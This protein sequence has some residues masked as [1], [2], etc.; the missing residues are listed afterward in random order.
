MTDNYYDAECFFSKDEGSHKDQLLKSSKE[1]YDNIAPGFITLWTQVL[2]YF[3]HRSPQ[4]G[5]FSTL[6]S[7][8]FAYIKSCQYTDKINQKN[9][10]QIA[11]LCSQVTEFKQTF[12]E[13]TNILHLN[14]DFLYTTLTAVFINQEILE[15]QI[16]EL[17]ERNNCLSQQLF[18]KIPI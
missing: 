12:G 8:L 1:L 16:N 6:S 3:T 14:Q 18:N 13:Y 17:I 9:Q 4:Q 2:V 11:E 5:V 15:N 10:E 7:G